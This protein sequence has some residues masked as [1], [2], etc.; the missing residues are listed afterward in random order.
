MATF[1]LFWSLKNDFETQNVEIFGKVFHNFGKSEDVTIKMLISNRC[2][3]S[4]MPNLM[5]K[6]MDG[7]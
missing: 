3:S 6:I 1:E 4:L 2:I 7:L 5:K